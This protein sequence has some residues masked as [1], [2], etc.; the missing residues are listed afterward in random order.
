MLTTR[1]TPLLLSSQ[2][3]KLKN[4]GDL[5][6]L[7]KDLPRDTPLA[8]HCQGGTRS[9]IAASLMQAQGFTNVSNV[10]GGF[11][12]WK[13]AGLPVVSSDHTSPSK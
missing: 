9:A 13:S 5:V 10:S 6:E 12:A 4:V 2:I 8:L 11:R 7:T 1:S 3:D